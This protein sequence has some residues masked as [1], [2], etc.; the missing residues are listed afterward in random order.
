MGF[1]KKGKRIAALLAIYAVCLVAALFPGYVPAS[2]LY[3]THLFLSFTW[4]MFLAIL[5]FL[6]IAIFWM[7]GVSKT[8]SVLYGMLL[9]LGADYLQISQLEKLNQARL[10]EQGKTTVAI[11]SERYFAR[12][13]QHAKVK[14]NLEGTAYESY[15]F[16]NYSGSI[17]KLGDSVQV[18]YW[19]P[20]PNLCEV[21]E[22]REL[23]D[24]D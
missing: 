22:F 21:I 11:V 12:G 9:G 6:P 14:F 18:L 3:T 2:Y 4:V 7:L 15:S 24:S 20:N 19:E 10:V 16:Q 8:K 17:Y 1:D 5:T 23:P 13:E